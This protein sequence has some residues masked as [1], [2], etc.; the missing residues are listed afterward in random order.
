MTDHPNNAL[1]AELAACPFCGEAPKWRGTRSDY[2]R[3]IFRLQCLGE[4]HLVQSYGATE[5]AAIA[6]WNTR[7]AALR[8]GDGR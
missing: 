7:P 5:S 3:G 4:T 8:A 1:A 6:A 2:A